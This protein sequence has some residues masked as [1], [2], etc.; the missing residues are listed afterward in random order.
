[1]GLHHNSEELM[2]AGTMKHP[3][4]VCALISLLLDIKHTRIERLISQ[5]RSIYCRR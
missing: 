4:A 1:M 5:M 3:T 2:Y